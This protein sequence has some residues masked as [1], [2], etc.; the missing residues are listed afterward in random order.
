MSHERTAKQQMDA[1]PRGKSP[2][3][4]PQTRWRNYVE[5]LAWSR[6]GILPAKLPLVARRSG[7]LEIPTRAAAPA[8]PKG[9][10]CKGKYTELLQC[11][12]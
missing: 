9:Q 12:P 2:R 4:R 10:A 3:G 7:C 8:T 5:E 6:L 11:F 1:L